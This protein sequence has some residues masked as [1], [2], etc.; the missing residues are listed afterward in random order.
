MAI[1]AKRS[2]WP[3]PGTPT[4]TMYRHDRTDTHHP[5]IITTTTNTTA[6]GPPYIN[7]NPNSHTM[8]WLKDLV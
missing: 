5:I 4:T 1:C 2:T 7:T 8:Q 3:K 6:P